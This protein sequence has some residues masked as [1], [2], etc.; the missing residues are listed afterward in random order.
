MASLMEFKCAGLLDLSSKKFPGLST[1]HFGSQLRSAY[2]FICGCVFPPRMLRKYG[3]HPRELKHIAKTL[4]KVLQMQL[5]YVFRFSFA[6]LDL[7]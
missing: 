1:C 7:F 5:I 3:G 4:T 2:I 6:H